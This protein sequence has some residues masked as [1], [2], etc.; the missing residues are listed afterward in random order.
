MKSKTS[1]GDVLAIAAY[2]HHSYIPEFKLN[3]Q[4]LNLVIKSEEN[5]SVKFDDSSHEYGFCFCCSY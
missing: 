3:F 1:L 5:N 4:K 2:K